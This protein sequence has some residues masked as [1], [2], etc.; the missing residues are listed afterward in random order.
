M[1]EDLI[2]QLIT[3]GDIKTPTLIKAFRRI[4]RVDFLPE[5]VTAE[6]QVNTPL[7]IGAGQTN[8]QPQTVAFMLELLQPQEGEKILDI[9]SGS[10]WTT[11]LLAEAVGPTGCV[12]AIER[13]IELKNFGENNVRKYSLNNVE[14]FC[15]DGYAGL[16]KFMPFAKILVSAAAYEIPENLKIQL[17]VGGRLVVP[18]INQDIRVIDKIS[19]DKYQQTIYPGFIFVPLI[20]D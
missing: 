20:K 7:P 14:F 3:A 13:L 1:S 10:G 18:T 19:S 12:Y 6:A 8:S 15:Q 9:G 11:A 4:K 2:E 16:A 17:A 5:E